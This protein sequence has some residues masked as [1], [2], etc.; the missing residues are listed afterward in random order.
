MHFAPLLIVVQHCF[1]WR[2]GALVGVVL[3]VGLLVVSLD[4]GIHAAIC[5]RLDVVRLGL[6]SRVLCACH[7]GQCAERYDPAYDYSDITH[8]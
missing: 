5:L 1:A 3:D 7:A 2:I 8:C 4:I 6:S